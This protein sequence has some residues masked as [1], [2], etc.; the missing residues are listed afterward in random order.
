MWVLGSQ[1]QKCHSSLRSVYQPAKP[2]YLELLEEGVVILRSRALHA[3]SQHMHAGP[4]FIRFSG[5]PSIRRVGK[6]QP[7]NARNLEWIR[8]DLVLFGHTFGMVRTPQTKYGI[9]MAACAHRLST[10]VP[11]G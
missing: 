7:C 2:R 5:R 1:S 6:A 8:A 3:L 9:D 10:I 4:K 11:E